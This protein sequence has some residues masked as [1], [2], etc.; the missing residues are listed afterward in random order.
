MAAYR[1]TQLGSRIIVGTEDEAVLVCT[2]LRVARQAVADAELLETLP[3]K[4]VFSREM[5]PP[6]VADD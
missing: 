2:S 3:A 4:Q 6:V 1:I 5:P